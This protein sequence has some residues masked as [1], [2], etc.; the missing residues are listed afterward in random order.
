MSSVGTGSQVCSLLW[1]SHERELLSAHGF[2]SNQLTLWKYPSMVRVAELEGH[3]S[4]VL[5]MAK[6]FDEIISLLNP[7]FVLVLL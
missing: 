1:S 6:V 3:T 7:L 5:S 2:S 4:R